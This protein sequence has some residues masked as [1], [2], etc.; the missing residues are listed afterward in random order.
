MGQVGRSLWAG[1]AAARLGVHTS[2]VIY[3]S[4][5]IYTS[6]V[7]RTGLVVRAGFVVAADPVA[8]QVFVTPAW[9]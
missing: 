8:E 7:I 1:C 4:L 5:L 9:L 2:L 3:T 6:L